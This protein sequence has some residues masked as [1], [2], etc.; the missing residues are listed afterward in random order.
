LATH[1]YVRQEGI[2]MAGTKQRRGKTA[3]S[4]DNKAAGAA[5]PAAAPA[6]AAA[7]AGDGKITLDEQL[8]RAL[9]S[10][11]RNQETALTLHYQWRTHLLRM[12]YIVMIVSFHQVQL[13]SSAC[14]NEIK[15]WN[16]IQKNTTMEGTDNV[17]S[18]FQAFVAVL[19]D[20]IVEVLGIVCC[21]S[22]LWCLSLPMRN[23]DFAT[24]PY[25]LSCTLIPMIVSLYWSNKTKTGGCL[26][27]FDTTTTTTTMIEDMPERTP[28]G[29]PVVLVF[30]LIVS[31]S[32]W[33]MKFQYSQ[34]G[35]NVAMVMKMKKDLKDAQKISKSS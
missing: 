21:A 13:P 27:D 2:I 34:H 35:K 28:G 4:N 18:G 29:F 22:L 26:N 8:D 17:V 20:S 6:V 30:H 32:L 31:I 33:F 10:V 19:N 11:H 5:A 14:L 16:E 3:S 9:A 24:V 23:Q 1:S 25:R 7:A 12:T 15:Q